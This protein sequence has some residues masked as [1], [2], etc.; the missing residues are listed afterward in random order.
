METQILKK[1]LLI[2]AGFCAL[3]LLHS[4]KSLAQD[5]LTDS[6]KSKFTNIQVLPQFPGGTQALHDF[7][8][9]NVIYPKKALKK[10]IEG[11]VDVTFV[12]E[13]DGSLSHVKTVGNPNPLLVR[14]AVRLIKSSPKWSPGMQDNRTVRVQYTVPI[15]FRLQ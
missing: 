8:A 9:K 1:C 6:S 4:S 2:F 3:S 10:D 15:V 14:E 5:A 11:Q 13:R 12:V 7:I